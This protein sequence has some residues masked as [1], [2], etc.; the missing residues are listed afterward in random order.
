MFAGCTGLQR[1]HKERQFLGNQPTGVVY[2]SAGF[3]ETTWG[4]LES[5]A[6]GYEEIHEGTHDVSR[7]LTDIDE[8]ATFDR[9]YK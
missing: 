6:I 5:N 7:Y 3:C 8:S 2:E 9:K 1:Q 4:S